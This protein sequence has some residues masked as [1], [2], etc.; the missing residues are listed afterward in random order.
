MTK[1]ISW[2]VNGLRAVLK[3][4]MFEFLESK[5]PDILALQ[6]IKCLETDIE[7]DD[8]EQLKKNYHLYFHSAKK[9]GY[10]GVAIFIEKNFYEKEFVHMQTKLSIDQFDD[11]GRSL[12]LETKNFFFIN[13]YF[14]NGQRDHGRV[15][16][17]LEFSYKILEIAEKLKKEKPVIICGDINTAHTEIDLKNP[18]SNINT[19][20]FLPIERK[21]IDDLITKGFIDIFREHNPKLLDAYTWWTYRSNCR[22][23]NI[24]WRLDYFF[25]NREAKSK[26]AK[27]EIQNDVFGSDHCPVCLEL[28]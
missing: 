13:G 7:N 8:L 4:E 1:L 26:V 23:K 15:D 19:T 24:G 22:E 27:I 6:E 2:N 10:S 11:E 17:K 25:I 28:N 20:G 5:R 9:K 16:Y 21:F 3:K 14:P 12:I 18:K